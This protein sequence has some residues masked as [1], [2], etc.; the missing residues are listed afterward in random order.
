MHIWDAATKE[1]L[2]ILQG[3][4]SGG[5]CSLDF[6]CTGKMLLTVGLE[7]EHNVTVWRWQDGKSLE[8]ECSVTR[9]CGGGKMIRAWRWQGDK[10]LEVE[11]AR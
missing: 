1:T 4:H 8:E 2:S 6:S 7:E 9:L 3:G 5:I 11:V 10:S